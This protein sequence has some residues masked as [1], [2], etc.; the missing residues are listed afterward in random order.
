MWFFVYFY[1][2]YL[3]NVLTNGVELLFNTII[4]VGKR[5]TLGVILMEMTPPKQSIKDLLRGAISIGIPSQQPLKNNKGKG[6]RNPPEPLLSG[7]ARLFFACFLFWELVCFLGAVIP[8]IATLVFL[9]FLFSC[10][11]VT[12]ATLIR[13]LY[14]FI[15][16]YAPS[17]ALLV[18]SVSCIHQ[19][20]A[21][22]AKATFARP[23]SYKISFREILT[24]QGTSFFRR[25][26]YTRKN[27]PW[28]IYRLHIRN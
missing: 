9:G 11:R 25:K 2:I 12:F 19:S 27:S 4:L 6:C 1:I 3:I 28:L 10:T 24:R 21:H 5:W 17:L 20:T 26:K 14:F 13:F 23:V 7:R 15:F 16:W 8:S 22:V 18:R